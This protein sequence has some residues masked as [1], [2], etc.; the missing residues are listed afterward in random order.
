MD[1]RDS[2]MAGM[3]TTHAELKRRKNERHARAI[4]SA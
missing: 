2:R 4:A 1:R 3:N